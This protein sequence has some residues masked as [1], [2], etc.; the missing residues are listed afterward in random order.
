[1]NISITNKLCG[2]VFKFVVILSR[3]EE[4]QGNIYWDSSMAYQNNRTQQNGH[5]Q[6][7]FES[8]KE[9]KRRYRW[10]EEKATCFLE[11]DNGNFDLLDR[12]QC[13][14]QR[15]LFVLTPTPSLVRQNLTKFIQL[16]DAPRHAGQFNFSSSL[17]TDNYSP[18][19][20]WVL[21]DNDARFNNLER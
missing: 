17:H 21:Y 20:M 7:S 13:I 14:I 4:K 9:K 19:A 5:Y 8:G 12:D 15:W 11:R 18:A 2:H 1:M 6:L 10:P 16:P 3:I